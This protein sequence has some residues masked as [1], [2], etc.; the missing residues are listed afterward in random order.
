MFLS[1][2][3]SGTIKHFLSSLV[4]SLHHFFS[5]KAVLIMYIYFNIDFLSKK[6]S[7]PPNIHYPDL[8]PVHLLSCL[9]K[10]YLYFLVAPCILISLRRSNKIPYTESFYTSEFLSLTFLSDTISKSH[11]LKKLFWLLFFMIG[12]VD[13]Q[14]SSKCW[15]GLMVKNCLHHCSQ[16]TKSQGR[17]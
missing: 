8:S 11:H 13:P 2:C 14:A 9:L 10:Y 16:K 17:S 7:I 12:L 15:K 3:I 6:S 4:L 1:S 5:S